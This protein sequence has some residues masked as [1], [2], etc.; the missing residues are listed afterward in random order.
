MRDLYLIGLL[1]GWLV[2]LIGVA[3]AALLLQQFFGLK[4]R[5]PVGRCAFLTFLRAVVY[6]GL[7]FFLLGPALIDKRVT[8]LRRPL[9]LLIDSSQ[10]MGFPASAKSAPGDKNAQS[11]LDLVKEKLAAGSN[12]N[13]ALIQKLSRDYDLRLIRLGTSLEPIAAG[14]LAALKPQDPGTRLLELLPTAARDG[15]AP[16]A[17]ILF[18]DGITNGD[19]KS[20]DGAPALPVPVFTV[21]VGDAEGFT[22]VRIAK[23]GAPCAAL[24]VAAAF[25]LPPRDPAAFA[26]AS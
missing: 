16:S 4:K 2:V 20:L 12:A 24:A 10:S 23:V 17:V 21:G 6:A 8:K 7:I 5:L 26:A 1:P 22:D 25:A 15:A 19:K 9:T 14:S 13:D 3:A 18:S 11:R